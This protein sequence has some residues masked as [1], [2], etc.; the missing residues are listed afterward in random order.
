MKKNIVISIGSIVFVWLVW[1]VAYFA[2]RN[3]YLL[4]SFW[5][6]FS[7]MG[8]LFAGAEFWL[9]FLNTLLRTL[10]A[11]V[12]SLVLGVGLALCAR[13]CPYVRTFLA[14][15]VSIMRTLPTMA[16]ILLLLLW[17]NP[18][19]APVIV[20]MLVLFPAV[21]AAA[22]A[23]FDETEERYGV[24]AR[25]YGVGLKNRVFKMYLPLAFPS[26]FTQ[27]GGILSLGIK[28][29]VSGEVLSSTY[30]SLGGLMQSAKMFVDIPTLLALTIVTLL[31][32][33]LL[34]GGCYLVGKKIVR[35]RQ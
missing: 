35:W 30:K 7:A 6:T 27:A 8:T 17:T 29:T 9:A 32:G 18:S 20:S 33:F 12:I 21:Y 1:I 15:I 23:A 3:D 16:V 11:F 31:L 2:I 28:I 26:L 4:P 13:L 34:E 24:I 10:L 5:E 22:L 14:P 25:S 19:V